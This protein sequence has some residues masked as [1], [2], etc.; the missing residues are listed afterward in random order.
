MTRTRS[1]TSA[2]KVL[3]NR[4]AKALAFGARTGVIN[5][6]SLGPE[7][8]IEGRRELGVPVP[9]QEAHAAQLAIHRQDMGLLGDPCRIGLGCHSFYGYAVSRAR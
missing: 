3:T 9:Y 7:H 8:L 6:G 1:K 4:S 2:R 5:T